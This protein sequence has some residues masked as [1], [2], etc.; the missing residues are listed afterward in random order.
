[1]RKQIS[2]REHCIPAYDILSRLATIKPLPKTL[3][4]MEDKTAGGLLKKLKAVVLSN[5]FALLPAEATIKVSD[6]QQY[7]WV[8]ADA[9][10]EARQI[11]TQ[12]K[13]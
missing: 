4:A 8:K 6:H 9:L 11:W 2:I 7:H 10:E 3:A 13:V 12:C 5:Y 1:M